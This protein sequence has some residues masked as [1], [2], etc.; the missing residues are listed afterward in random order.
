MF[1]ATRTRTFAR[2]ALAL[3]LAFGAAACDDA[4]GEEHSDA[5]GM[6]IVDEATNQVLVSV[7]A[8]RQVN[9]ALSVRAGQE[10]AL[11]VYFLDEDGDRMSL[12]DDEQL[13]WNVANTAV[14]QIEEHDGHLDLSGVTAG[15]TTVVLSI[16]HGGHSDYDSPTIP[17]TVTP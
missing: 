16:Q 5:E 10:R 7:N 4:T 3:S 2:A 13:S 1:A 9:G 17:I 8:A 14:A 12:D 11:E 15:S 6:Q